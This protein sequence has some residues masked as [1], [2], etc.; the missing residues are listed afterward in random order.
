MV[1]ALLAGC[2]S[3]DAELAQE[4]R[5]TW[6]VSIPVGDAATRS[7]YLDG[8]ALKSKWNANQPVI[9]YSTGEDPV[10]M[11][12]ASESEAGEASGASTL[13]TGDISGTYTANASTLTLYSPAKLTSATYAE[14]ATQD[15]TV[16][17]EKGISSKD[18]MTATVGV[19]A[20]D[21]SS[22]L[23][24]TEK[25]T[26]SRLQS[27]TKFKFTE[28]VKTLVISATGMSNITIEASEDKDEFYVALP[29]AGAVTYTFTGTTA[30]GTV[31]SVQAT[32]TLTLGSY[33]SATIDFSAAF[34]ASATIN[35]WGPG[36]TLDEGNL[37][38]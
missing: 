32:G 3:D 26:F 20:V 6:H 13:I 19:T 5:Q 23:L 15:G 21:A 8:T 7:V 10:G 14:Y 16:D 24:G 17:G 12:A 2:S 1:A 27:F 28:A 37:I 25:G 31:Y 33:Y 4:P 30:S 11:L 34:N 36:D 35:N 29:L 38:Y 22:G 9:A 18:Y